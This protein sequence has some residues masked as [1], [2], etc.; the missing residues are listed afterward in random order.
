MQSTE[1]K[2]LIPSEALN[3][4]VPKEAVASTSATDPKTNVRY[5]YQIG[6]THFL[7][8]EKMLSEVLEDPRI[9]AVPK[10]VDWLKGILNVRGNIVPV[11]DLTTH[12]K[13]PDEAIQ[14]NNQ[15]VIVLGKGSESA[16]II[17]NKLPESAEADAQNTATSDE[18]INQ[19]RLPDIFSDYVSFAF[20]SND[21]E[22]MEFDYQGFLK[23]IAG[24]CK[25][26]LSS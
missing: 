17:I 4:F 20:A 24:Q 19:M 8:G 21:V 2:W 3:R 6:N 11:F 12:L 15:V 14:K 5:G 22:W 13:S 26:T 10:S 25:A 23:S 1:R 7:V 16:G 18:P 9:Y